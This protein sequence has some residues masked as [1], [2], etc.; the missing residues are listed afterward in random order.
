LTRMP[1]CNDSIFI[2]LLDGEMKYGL[3]LR[4]GDRLKLKPGLRTNDCKRTVQF[5]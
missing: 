5:S 1:M 3:S 4:R 2:R